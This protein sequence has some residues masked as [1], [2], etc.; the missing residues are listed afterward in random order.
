M[1]Q[2]RAPSVRIQRSPHLHASWQR[3]PR[4]TSR[5]KR[6]RPPWSDAPPSYTAPLQPPKPRRSALQTRDLQQA[7]RPQVPTV[8]VPFTLPLLPALLPPCHSGARGHCSLAK[9]RVEG[10]WLS[11]TDLGPCS[12]SCWLCDSNEPSSL[13]ESGFSYPKSEGCQRWFAN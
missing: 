5:G 6:L 10:P 13:S 11:G 3:R 8:S 12:A 1:I 7:R 4:R 9:A 2:T